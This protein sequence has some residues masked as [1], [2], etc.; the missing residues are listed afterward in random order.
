MKRKW[1]YGCTLGLFALC[2]VGMVMKVSTR[3]VRAESVSAEKQK[4]AEQKERNEEFYGKNAK[5]YNTDQSEKPEKNLEPAASAANEQKSKTNADDKNGK[6]SA[7]VSGIEEAPRGEQDNTEYREYEESGHSV[8]TESGI[9]SDG[10]NNTA[11][12]EE[13]SWGY[14]QNEDSAS[15]DTPTVGEPVEPMDSP[16]LLDPP[17]SLETPE[18][19]ESPVPEDFPAPTESPAPEES[20]EPTQT[21]DPTESPAPT[22]SP[23]PTETPSE[24]Q[25]TYFSIEMKADKEEV[26]A[27]DTITY[28]VLLSNT[29]EKDLS[30]LILSDIFSREDIKI[31]WKE[32]ERFHIEKETGAVILNSL[33]AG[34]KIRIHLRVA[35]PED[36]TQPLEHTLTMIAKDPDDE[37][38][39]LRRKAEVCTIIVPLSVDYEVEKSADYGV[40]HPGD[41]VTY[42]IRIKNTGERILHSIITTERFLN[43]GVQAYFLPQEGILLNKDRTQAYIAQLEPEKEISIRA[44]VTMPESAIGQELVNQ[45]YVST[46]ETGE[47]NQISEATVKV[48]PA[49]TTATPTPTTPPVISTSDSG[50]SDFTPGNQTVSPVQTGDSSEPIH[51]VRLT[52]ASLLLIILLFAAK[53]ARR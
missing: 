8:E 11:D 51:W 16:N 26:K 17:V 47:K 23:T 44:S 21:P 1:I 30:E 48:E 9:M 7:G 3:A 19:S 50:N 2:C 18:P 31:A 13:G 32:S 10:K 22:E 53:K 4:N 40:A 12:T 36:M 29:G 38:N 41:V 6:E 39:F 14:E 52:A 43:D 34:E 24:E 35:V 27:G 20:P 37:N 25:N 5:I 46:K 42:T 33:K 49:E 45:V 28:E 15:T